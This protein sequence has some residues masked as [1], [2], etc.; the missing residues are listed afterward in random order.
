MSKFIPLDAQGAALAAK[1]F[2]HG[3]IVAFPTETVYGLAA[4]ADD[5]D[6][7][8][9][10]YALKNRPEDKPLPLCL[11]HE[12]AADSYAEISP[13]VRRLM[14]AFWP[15]PLTIVLPALSVFRLA[16]QVYGPD[17]TVALR[18]PKAPF[19]DMLSSLSFHLPLALT[20]ANMSGEPETHSA[21]EVN[22]A[23]GDRVPLIIDGG[24]LAPARPSTI[25]KVD[26]GQL[27]ILREG[28]ICEAALRQ[29][30]YTDANA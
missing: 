19:I 18:R 4:R 7:L 16:P 13:A 27:T 23:L 21:I 8:S 6:A 12:H 11:A 3:D 26:G 28:D 9:R 24:M 30:A 1:S 2:H 25:V 17:G 22:R 5:P 29:A 20:S 10:L 15:G 14:A